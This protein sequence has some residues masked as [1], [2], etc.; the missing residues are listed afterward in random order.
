ME[1]ANSRQD[2]LV[3][4]MDEHPFEEIGTTIVTIE[5]HLR[6]WLAVISRER[7]A[8]RQI[9]AYRELATLFE[10]FADFKVLSFEENAAD[11]FEMLRSASIRVGTNDLKIAAIAL[12]NDA[13][14]VT[15]NRQDFEKVPNLP[16]ENW[17]D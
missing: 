5:E 2:R 9:P 1:D 4:H 15:A 16:F 11:K 17:L 3:A 6:G 7:Q 10:F 12:A 13:L 8:R 14:L